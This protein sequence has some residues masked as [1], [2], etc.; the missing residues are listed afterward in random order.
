MPLL[1]ASSPNQVRKAKRHC[2]VRPFDGGTIRFTRALLL[3]GATSLTTGCGGVGGQYLFTHQIHWSKPDLNQQQLNADWYECKKE[4]TPDPEYYWIV[5]EG[6][7][8]QC[9]A[10]KGYTYTEEGF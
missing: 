7:A 6:M 9:M 3:V 8:K 2:V 4:N 10:A 1:S 5:D